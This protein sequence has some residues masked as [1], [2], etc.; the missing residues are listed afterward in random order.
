MLSM[1][2]RK[3]ERV[4]GR[5]RGKREKTAAPRRSRH[6]IEIT[7]RDRAFPLR[8]QSLSRDEARSVQRERVRYDP[9]RSEPL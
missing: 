3:K 5:K 6:D 9:D 1:H 4:G 8:P 2:S 7:M